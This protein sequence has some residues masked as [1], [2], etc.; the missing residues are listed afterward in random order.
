MK[1]EIMKS[2]DAIKII[3]ITFKAHSI[4]ILSLTQVMKT[5]GK[6]DQTRLMILSSSRVNFSFFQTHEIIPTTKVMKKLS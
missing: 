6:P 3:W 1:L 2:S 4:R 5:K